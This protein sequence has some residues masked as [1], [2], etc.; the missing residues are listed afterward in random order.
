[1]KKNIVFVGL[2]NQITKSIAN[3]LSKELDMF[4]LDINDLIKYNF[5]NEDD[6]IFKVGIEYYDNQIK[7]IIKGASSY[8]NTIFNCPYDLFLNDEIF[9]YF[10]DNH[11]IY[12]DIPKQVLE[13]I[14]LENNIDNKLDVQLL[15]YDEFKTKLMSKTNVSLKYTEI[16]NNIKELKN[17]LT[18]L[19]EN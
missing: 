14:S 5:K 6:V 1:M 7:K 16:N 17:I 13:K 3:A 2:D 4:F 18:T 9:N 19:G 8:E 11:L 10:K 12:I 15:A